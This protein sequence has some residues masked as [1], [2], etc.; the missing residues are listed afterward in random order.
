MTEE[1]KQRLRERFERILSEAD[2]TPRTIDDIEEIALQV[3]DKVTQAVAEE[4]A[5]EA[6]E[7]SESSSGSERQVDSKV[8]C[9]NCQGS[10]W[11]KG[12]R[13]R[14]LLTMAGMVSVCRPYY[15]CRRCKQGF[16]PLD[17][18]L[19][20]PPGSHFTRSVC[21]E[22]AYLSAC[23]PFEQ[24]VQTL[25]RLAKVRV[26]S[27][28]AERLCLAPA[29]EAVEAFL[30]ERESRNLPKA[31]ADLSSLSDSPK[32]AV[33][34]LA[35][36]GIQTP[37]EDGSWEEMKVGVVC[38]QHAD[39]REFQTSRYVNHL[40]EANA[41]GIPL[42]ALAIDCGSL[43][44]KTL[45]FLGD[46]AAWLWKLAETRFPRAIQILDFWHALEYVGAVAREAFSS[47]EE[48]G[49]EWLSARASEM[50]RS[51]W[52]RAHVASSRF[53]AVAK[54]TVESASRY[55]TNHRPRMDYARYLKQG[56]CIGSGLAE[57]SC[58]RLVTQR[59]KGSGMHWS[60]QGAQ[61]ICSLRG[62][63]LGGGMGILVAFWNRPLQKPILSPLL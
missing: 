50:K 16:S 4:V 56:L 36:D 11:F 15:Y 49:K 30:A 7:D 48:A 27:R 12:E 62:L 55:F 37:M 20:L 6:R 29:K 21:Q 31:F 60:E 59:L 13:S 43:A 44:A 18:R 9:P 54:E 41:F 57:S 19:C 52:E 1:T 17:V 3:R 35:A 24:A 38:A 46:G 42:E 51:A 47:D 25:Y 23:L 14:Q 40:G 26:S 5:E 28:S 8:C 63:L 2:K 32:P 34:Y 61:I 33:L 10:A 22:V 39:G 53:R 58:K 45:V